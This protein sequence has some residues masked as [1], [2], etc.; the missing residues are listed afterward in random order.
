[1]TVSAKLFVRYSRNEMSLGNSGC[2][3]LYGSLFGECVDRRRELDSSGLGRVQ[4]QIFAVIVID[5]TRPSAYYVCITR[6]NV[7]EFYIP[8]ID[9]NMFSVGV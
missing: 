2:R 8:P 7:K 4:R 6:F 3:V 9:C 5:H 1:M